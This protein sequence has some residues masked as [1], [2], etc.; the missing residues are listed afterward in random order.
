[1]QIQGFQ[2]AQSSSSTGSH[3]I[4]R[5]YIHTYI[6]IY[7]YIYKDDLPCSDHQFSKSKTLPR[8]QQV[9]I[10]KGLSQRQNS[11]K[12]N[13]SVDIVPLCKADIPGAVECIQQSFADDPF[14]IWAFDDPS[15]VCT[16]ASADACNQWSRKP[17]RFNRN[18]E[19]KSKSSFCL[20]F[21]HH[22][23]RYRGGGG[24]GLWGFYIPIIIFS[25][26]SPSSPSFFVW[27]IGAI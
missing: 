27:I 6:H 10:E 8:D 14:F 1:M 15:K 3:I 7:I 24:N 21:P 20:P 11:R 17:P 16:R 19:P 4:I 26:I 5:V 9:G 18:L 12:R 2:A 22:P 23:H 13:M 25:L